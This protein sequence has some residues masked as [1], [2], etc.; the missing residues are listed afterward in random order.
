MIHLKTPTCSAFAANLKTFSLS[1][2]IISWKTDQQGGKWRGCS[3][4]ELSKSKHT[5][6]CVVLHWPILGLKMNPCAF[7]LFSCFLRLSPLY[8]SQQSE[9]I[10]PCR[11]CVLSWGATRVQRQWI[12]TGKA[13]WKKQKQ[14]AESCFITSSPRKNKGKTLTLYTADFA[15]RKN[16]STVMMSF[17]CVMFS[18]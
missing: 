13:Q 11:Q 17:S 4:R 12:I 6:F 18:T 8:S 9:K 3:C 10:V 16:N 5:I 2:S 14:P 15:F 7:S 1:T